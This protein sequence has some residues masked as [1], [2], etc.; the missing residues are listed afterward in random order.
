DGGGV[1]DLAG[2]ALQSPQVDQKGEARA[3][4]ACHPGKA[5]ADHGVKG[6]LKVAEP[7][8]P[9]GAEPHRLQQLI[10]KPVVR[11]VDKLPKEEDHH[12]GHDDGRGEEHSVKVSRSLVADVK[13]QLGGE[14]RKDEVERHAPDNK[15]DD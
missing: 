12:D 1:E 7:R 15:L 2:N 4:D 5:E 11:V 13:D 14:Q 9:P 8:P 6:G 3:A 10:E